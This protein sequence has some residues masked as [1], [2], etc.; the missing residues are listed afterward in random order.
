MMADFRSSVRHA[1]CAWRVSAATP[2]VCGAAIDVPDRISAPVPVPT[3]VDWM[4]TPGAVTSGFRLPSPVRGPPEVKLANARKPGLVM[5]LA[6]SVAD[7]ASAA[8]RAPPL[9]DGTPRNGIVTVKASPVSGLD[10]I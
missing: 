7:V 3:A 2:L 4:L 8:L 5:L 9:L 1:G 10:V 6:V